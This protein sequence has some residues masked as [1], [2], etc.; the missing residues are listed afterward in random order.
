MVDHVRTWVRDNLRAGF[1]SRSTQQSLEVSANDGTSDSIASPLDTR[2]N[3][4]SETH[5]SESVSSALVSSA[6]SVDQDASPEGDVT[7]AGQDIDA[8]DFDLFTA[9]PRQ[10]I[11]QG[12]QGIHASLLSLKLVPS[13]V[14]NFRFLS[15]PDGERWLAQH[16]FQE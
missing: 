13:A 15:A 11:F 14:I 8:P 16:Q 5:L 4:L 9:P 2:N 10:S 12:A 7:S 1:K 6:P 3:T